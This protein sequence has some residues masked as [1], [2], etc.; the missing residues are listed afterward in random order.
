MRNVLDSTPSFHTVGDSGAD[1]M[2]ARAEHMEA[3]LSA[4]G[5]E[6]SVCKSVQ[7]LCACHLLRRANKIG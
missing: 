7:R 4:I 3:S 6:G 2:L 1:A 5:V